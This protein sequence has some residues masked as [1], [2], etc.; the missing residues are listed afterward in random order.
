M[1]VDSHCHLTDDAFDGDRSE[2][3]LRARAAGVER[4]VVVASHRVDAERVARLLDEAGSVAAFPRLWGTAGIHPHEAGGVSPDDLAAIR[5]L[6]GTH[7]RMVAVGETGLDFHYDLS[8]RDVQ[9]ALFRQHMN[10]AEELGL[11]VVVHSRN[12]DEATARVL[13][14]WGARVRGV[15]HC[16]TGGSALLDTAMELGWM[17]SF[18]GIITFKKYAAQEL[19]RGI[20]RDRLM[21]ETDAPYLA[22]LPHRG[23]RNEPA[24][25]VRVAEELAAIRGEDPEAVMGYTS[26][27]AARFFNLSP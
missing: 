9:E 16:Y 25:V 15:L 1:L 7:P 26:Q 22:P 13:R 5:G 20:P 2:A 21:V 12:A 27:N 10:L 14:E 23:R 18:T 4:I 19:V 24:L 3:L 6:I 17:V 11:P 8:P